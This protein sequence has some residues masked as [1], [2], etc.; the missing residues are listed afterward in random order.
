[1]GGD[2][3]QKRK[4]GQTG[5]E[6]S[7]VGLGTVKFGRNQGVKYP[8]AYDLPSDQQIQ[9]LL[10]V[11]RELGINLIDTAPAYGVSE[12][13]LGEVLQ[14]T[15]SDWIISTKVG[16][17]FVNG[18]SQFDFTEVG[19]Q[20]SIMRSLKRLKTDYLDIV[21]VHSNGS[22]EALIQQDH[23]FELLAKLKQQGV[24]RA[25]GMSTKTIAG[26]KLAVDQSDLAMVS[27]NPNYTDERDVI[28]YAHAKQKG[29]FIKKALASGHVDQL[30]SVADAMQF[31]LGTP[32]VSSVI[33]GTTNPIHLRECA[34]STF[35]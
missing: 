15:R 35:I 2:V 27:Y 8:E 9:D 19:M 26:G 22:D 10:V 13:R 30:V 17:N 1:L 34:E 5:I 33:V 16:E 12:E 6:V 31:A 18:E 23:V 7:T 25:Y 29:I 3:L 4:L 20:Q 24:I 28:A 32:G 21:L 11:A 14:G